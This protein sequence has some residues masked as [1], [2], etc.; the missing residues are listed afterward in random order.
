MGGWASSSLFK[1]ERQA[2]ASGSKRIQRRVDTRFPRKRLTEEAE[3]KS[4]MEAR[5]SAATAWSPQYPRR[6]WSSP[7]TQASKRRYLGTLKSRSE[8]TPFAYLWKT[9]R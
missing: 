6:S 9:A 7:E 1:A 3:V 2:R 5:S 4:S 8:I